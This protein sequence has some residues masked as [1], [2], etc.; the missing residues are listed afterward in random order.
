M[1]ARERAGIDHQPQHHAPGMADDVAAGHLDERLPQRGDRVPGHERPQAQ[2]KVVLRHEGQAA[3]HRQ[4]VVRPFEL[5]GE[6]RLAYH[7]LHLVGER[8]CRRLPPLYPLPM[9]ALGFLLHSY[10]CFRGVVFALS[11]VRKTVY[12]VNLIFQP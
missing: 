7:R 12:T 8:V 3:M 11:V 6:Y 2:G 5:E 10:L 4:G 9:R 1:K